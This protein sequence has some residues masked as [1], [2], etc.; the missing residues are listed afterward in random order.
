M[1]KNPVNK[2]VIV[3]SFFRN[4]SGSVVTYFLPV[5]FLKNYPLFKAEYSIA[6]SLCLSVLGLVS[7]LGGGIV[8]DLGEKKTLWSKALVCMVGTLMGIPL[9][10]VTT[11]FSTNFWTSISFY[12][13]FTLCT[14]CFSGSAISMMQNSSKKSI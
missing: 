11:I 14:A 4:I 12:A 13:I 5:F 1:I 3:A 7:A 2:W 6:N 9:I 8:A 10:Y